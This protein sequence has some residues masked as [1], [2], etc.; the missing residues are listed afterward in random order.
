MLVGIPRLWGTAPSLPGASP[1]EPC[2][3]SGD[4][5]KSQGGTEEGE[6][7]AG[8]DRSGKAAPRHVLH[9]SSVCSW[10]VSPAVS[11]GHVSRGRAASPSL[12][13]KLRRAPQCSAA[14]RR[15]SGCAPGFQLRVRAVQGCDAQQHARRQRALS[16]FLLESLV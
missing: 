8:H 10:R 9:L 7:L 6:I 4:D 2:G 15:C 3:N 14:R 1:A 11:P 5:G 12:V 13:A 16:P